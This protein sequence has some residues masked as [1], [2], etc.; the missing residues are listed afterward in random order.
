MVVFKFQFLAVHCLNIYRNAIY[1]YVLPL[2]PTTLPN[3]LV[4]SMDFFHRVPGIFYI[5]N[6]VICEEGNFLFLSNL[7]AFYLFLLLYSTG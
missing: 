4:G 6:Y 3:S 1:F 2:Y 7:Y 5:E